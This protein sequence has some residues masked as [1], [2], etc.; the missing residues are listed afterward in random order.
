MV[1]RALRDEEELLW[2]RSLDQLIVCSIYGTCKIKKN[3]LKLSHI[4]GSYGDVFE[5]SSREIED[6]GEHTRVS[7]EEEG[8]IPFY[9]KVFMPALKGTM[10]EL[11]QSSG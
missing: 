11:R 6:L 7:E 9:N 2:G 1:Q 10:Y 8:I 5:L 4:I 3:P